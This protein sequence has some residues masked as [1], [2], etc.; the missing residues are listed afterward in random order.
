MNKT[1][2]I[3][4]TLLFCF[5]SL[6]KS[7]H[8]QKLY[9]TS[10]GEWIFQSGII[11]QNGERLNTNMRFTMWFHAN[12]NVHLDLGNYFGLFSGISLRNIGFITDENDIKT[13]YRSYNLGIP[14]AIKIGSFKDKIFLFGGG[15]YEWMFHFKQKTFADG[16]KRKHNEWFSDRTPSFIPSFFAG[17][18]LPHNLQL[19]FKYYLKDFLNHDYQGS[20]DFSDYTGFTKTRI[21]YISLSVQVKNSKLKKNVAKT[22]NIASRQ[23]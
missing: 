13:K 11:E 23:L 7:A 10:G 18:Q 12:E 17:V 21:W 4:C 2:L 6:Y 1:V 5:T 8:A 3:L 9:T 20:G 15:E 16:I 22:E 19:K 14:L